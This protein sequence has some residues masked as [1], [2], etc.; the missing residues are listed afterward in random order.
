MLSATY[1]PLR[2]STTNSQDTLN[3][4]HTPANKNKCYTLAKTCHNLFDL[5]LLRNST[6][7]LYAWGNFFMSYGTMAFYA[8]LVNFAVYQGL[9]MDS[10]TLTITMI[11]ATNL[12]SRLAFSF[13]AN[14]NCVNRT[15]QYAVGT[16]GSGIMIVLC[17]FCDTF[18]SLM[19]LSAIFGIFRGNVNFL[20]SDKNT[21]RSFYPSAHWTYL[22]GITI[23][24]M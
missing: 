23:I 15:L 4:H 3:W 12:I 7:Q 24:S 19:V 22:W 11:G 17:I 1:R 6:F 21:T 10:A 5:S 16:I 20:S 18:P 9:D 13:I 2:Q 14:I 8:H